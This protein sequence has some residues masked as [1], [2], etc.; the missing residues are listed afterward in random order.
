[1]IKCIYNIVNICDTLFIV[2]YLFLNMLNIHPSIHPF[3]SSSEA[4]SQWQQA[5]E[6][7]PGVLL[8]S[9]V[10]QL[11]LGDPKT[12]PGQM[13]YIIPPA[14]SGSTQGYPTS[15]TCPENL[16]RKAPRRHPDQMSKPPQLAPF[17][18][19][20]Q[21]L[22]SELP[23][24]VWAP[25]PISKAEPS[26]PAEETHFTLLCLQSHS[27]SHYPKLMT[28]GEGWSE[29][30]LVN[31]KLCPPAQRP[32]HHYGPVQRMHFFWCCNNLPV[33]LTL[34]REQDPKILELLRSRQ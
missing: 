10:F 4:R 24:D 2:P 28:I 31:Q 25:Y 6:G 34:T 21:W 1:M 13:R 14:C 5:E 20:E 12:F 30:R 32:V 9:N 16:Q 19:K 15:W 11:L 8:L 27:F 7:S 26:H 3:S 23:L 17:D 22:Y 18:M 29:D 33:N